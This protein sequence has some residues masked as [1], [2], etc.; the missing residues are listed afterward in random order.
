RGW[1]RRGR[2]PGP[3]SGGV[4]QEIVLE[5]L[6]TNAHAVGLW[7]IVHAAAAPLVAS[8]PSAADKADRHMKGAAQAWPV[9]SMGTGEAPTGAGLSLNSIRTVRLP[10]RSPGR[11]PGRGAPDRRTQSDRGPVGWR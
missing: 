8:H 2:G 4:A 5:D 1:R 6:P 3:H 10:A 11:R 9:S 7:Q